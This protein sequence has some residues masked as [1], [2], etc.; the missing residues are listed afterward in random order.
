MQQ[1][2]QSNEGKIFYIKF[3]SVVFLFAQFIY[4]ILVNYLNFL[5]L[6]Y[7]RKIL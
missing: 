2:K 1:D 4:L 3:C 7:K 5:K 6:L